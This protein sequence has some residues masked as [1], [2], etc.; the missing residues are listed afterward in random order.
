MAAT[1]VTEMPMPLEE[2]PPL[3]FSEVMRDADMFVGVAS[4][5]NDPTWNDGGPEGRYRDYWQNYSFGAL[6]ASAKT[7]KDVSAT[8]AT[9]TQT[10]QA[11]F[12]R[13]EVSRSARQLA[14]IQDSLGERQHSDGAQ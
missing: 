11:M 8:P 9:A 3:V 10:C 4:V 7:R 2:I 1:R 6:N 14:D 12:V 13:G 5:G